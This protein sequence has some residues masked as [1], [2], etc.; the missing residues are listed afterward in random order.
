MFYR[1]PLQEGNAYVWRKARVTREFDYYETQQPAR[2]VYNGNVYMLINGFCMSS[3]ADFSAILSANRKAQ[4]IGEETGG[5][6]QG[7]SSGM[8]PEVTLSP[9][10]LRAV[11]P[12]QLYVNAVDMS[13]N[14]GRGTMPDYPVQASV[15]DVLAGKDVVME[16][17]MQ[18]IRE[19]QQR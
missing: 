18:V 13:L 3:A 10:P 5:G 8:L 17:A 14:K 6:Y 19:K 4:F 15:Q 11:I 12:L 7:N 9:V 1:K 16:K 2:D